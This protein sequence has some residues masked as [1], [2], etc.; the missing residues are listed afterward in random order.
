MS[1]H[2]FDPARTPA[3]VS[4]CPLMYLVAECS[5]ISA[6]CSMG[7]DRY[8]LRNV[9]S[10]INVNSCLS[11]NERNAAIS[12]M[13]I[14]GLVTVSTNKAFVLGRT[15]S[16]T[17][18]KFRTSTIVTSIPIAGQSCSKNWRLITKMSFVT[19]T[20]SPAFADMSTEI[21]TAAIPDEVTNAASA[22]SNDAIFFSSAAVVGL[23]VR[24]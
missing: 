9:L 13:Y 8:G 2:F 6:P 3:T 18:C 4:P 24:E 5:T 14:F 22:P 12:E 19:M 7:L 16:S 10:T 1:I 21:A 17:S 23:D 11:A 20:C 15:A